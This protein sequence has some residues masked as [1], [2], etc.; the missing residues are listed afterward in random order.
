ME[1]GSKV[2]TKHGSGVIIGKD[3]PES[4]DLWRWIVE[5]NNAHPKYTY[6][7]ESLNSRLCYFPWE[8]KE[9]S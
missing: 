8:V 1:I 7:V 2:T 4:N 3:L 5:I 6:F 9:Q